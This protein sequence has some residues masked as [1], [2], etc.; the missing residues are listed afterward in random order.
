MLRRPSPSS[1]P[2]ERGLAAAVHEGGEVD[3]DAR[4]D[5]VRSSRPETARRS[6]ADGLGFE[7]AD[8]QAVRGAEFVGVDFGLLVVGVTDCLV[9]AGEHDRCGC[10]R[11]M[12]PAVLDEPVGQ[13][14]EQLGVGGR[15]A[16]GAEVVD[17]GDDA[18]AE[19]VVPDAVDHDAGG[20][21]VG[22]VDDPFG[23]F[24][25]GR[26]RIVDCG[27]RI[28]GFEEAAGG[29]GGRGFGVAADED[30]FVGGVAVG[31]GEGVE[32]GRGW[33]VRVRSVFVEEGGDGGRGGELLEGVRRV[34]WSWAGSVRSWSSRHCSTVRGG[35]ACGRET[36]GWRGGCGASERRA[37]SRA[38]QPLAGALGMLGS[39]TGLS[40]NSR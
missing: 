21:G 24:E 23:Q 7:A 38:S 1:G 33:I 30:V 25:A 17:G 13:V 10:S 36:W 27:L 28:E 11:L 29:E 4:A 3:L 6:V 26:L 35:G 40:A 5:M 14:V 37:R 39:G 12:R 34:A 8:G 31:G 32:T 18:P 2:L 9:G 15:L 19:E 22:G 20:E 16:Q